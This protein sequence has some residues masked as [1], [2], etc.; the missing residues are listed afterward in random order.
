ME[1]SEEPHR[2]A[3]RGPN[4]TG[5]SSSAEV[6]MLC[7]NDETTFLVRQ[8]SLFVLLREHYSLALVVLEMFEEVGNIRL[9]F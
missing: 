7:N 2:M 3:V 6:V 9:P 8:S 1:P 5:L 4:C